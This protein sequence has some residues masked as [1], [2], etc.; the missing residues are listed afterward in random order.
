M[1]RR[2][3]TD[4]DIRRMKTDQWTQAQKLCKHCSREH[5]EHPVIM[6][7]ALGNEVRCMIFEAG[8]R[9]IS[10]KPVRGEH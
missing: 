10:Y 1:M 4:Q 3:I 6:H 7:D 2:K 9:S 8:Q 5:Y